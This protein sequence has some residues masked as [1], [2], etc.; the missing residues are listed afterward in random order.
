ELRPVLMG[1]EEAKEPRPLREVGKQRAIVTCQPAIK[2][3]IAPTFEGV[4]QPQG[5]HLTG[6]EAS[7]GM[8]RDS[9]HLL[10]DLV[11]QG[12]DKIHSRHTALLSGAGWHTAQRG[13]VVG[14]LQVQ[15]RA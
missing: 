11:E 13:G 9:A 8:F 5:D 2:R 4:E 10:I 15:K 14:R 12:S 1:P 7:L 3:A 6:P